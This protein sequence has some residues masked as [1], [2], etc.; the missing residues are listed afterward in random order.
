MIR[1]HPGNAA[2]FAC[3]SSLAVAIAILI[4]SRIDAV[5]KVN[6]A[7]D[8]AVQLANLTDDE[9]KNVVIRLERTTCY[10]SCPAY[11]L[12]IYR[13]GRVEYVG[14]SNVK[15]KG[16][17]EARIASVDFKRLVSEFDK[18]NYFSTDQF[19]EKKCSCR[20]CTDMPTA[21]TEIQ[22]KGS[23]HRIEHYYGCTC[24]PK[25]LWE[26]EQAIDKVVRTEQWT[27]D[28]SKQ[29]PFGTTCFTR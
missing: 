6:A 1:L 5:Q 14:G 25:T 10:G 15:L 8:K 2:F 3:L 27:G 23:T 20:F 26:L 12:A 13:N 24:A 11:K 7:Q 21:I 16:A 17:Q 29:G 9:L 18:A 19:T 22:E 28:V 4:L